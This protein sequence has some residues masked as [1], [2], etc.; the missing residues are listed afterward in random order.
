M[1]H[2]KTVPD[3]FDVIM[4]FM[5]ELEAHPEDAERIRQEFWMF[6]VG[7]ASEI[8]AGI[9]TQLAFTII[10]VTNS[11]D[12]SPELKLMVLVQMK[13]GL[14]YAVSMVD[15]AI[16]PLRDEVLKEKRIT[17][18]REMRHKIA[19]SIGGMGKHLERRKKN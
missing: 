5:K 12:L 16:V 9:Y 19:A 18:E 8:L 3:F 13:G 1:T 17:E 4:K 10:D 14:S 15:T 6:G 2:E 7:E 11:S